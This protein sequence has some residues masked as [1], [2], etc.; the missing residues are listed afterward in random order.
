M[1]ELEKIK[2]DN[3]NKNLLNE[4]DLVVHKKYGV[5]M[6][7]DIEQTDCWYPI[8]VRFS[9]NVTSFG[10]TQEKSVFRCLNTK[11]HCNDPLSGDNI[12]KFYKIIK[13]NE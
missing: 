5:G 2:E 4:G 7:T 3:P 1:T 11:G 6:I 12:A 8:V 13:T 9:Q 10:E